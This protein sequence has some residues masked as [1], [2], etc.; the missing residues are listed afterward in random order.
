MA[1]SGSNTTPRNSLGST[2]QTLMVD[3]R[4]IIPPAKPKPVK[5]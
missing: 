3:A 4:A 1:D 2:N 5:P